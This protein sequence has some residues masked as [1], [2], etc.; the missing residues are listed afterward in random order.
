MLEWY[1]IFSQ[2]ILSHFFHVL[3]FLEYSLICNLN[4]YFYYY[5]HAVYA[6][7]KTE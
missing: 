6:R 1:V 2:W 3:K 5:M 7:D 4:I